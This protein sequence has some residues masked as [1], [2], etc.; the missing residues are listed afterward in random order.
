MYNF[1]Y[2]SVFDQYT[3]QQNNTNTLQARY[4]DFRR[5]MQE[6]QNYDAFIN[7]IVQEALNKIYLR[8]DVSDALNKIDELKAA[9]QELGVK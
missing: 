7:E 4:A 2:N 1:Q 8:L 9:L 6:K 5:T 3:A